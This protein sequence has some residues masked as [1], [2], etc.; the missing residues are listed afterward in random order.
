MD[1]FARLVRSLE[2][3]GVRFVLIGLAGAN[4]YARSGA[5]LFVTEDRDLLLPLDPDNALAAWGV[6][7]AM[8][9]QLR[10]GREPLDRPRDRF[11]A[12]RVVANRALVRATDGAGLDVD[13]SL[14][15]AGLDFETVWAERRVFRVGTVDIPVARLGQSSSRNVAWDARR[16]GCS[17]QRTPRRSGSSARPTSGSS[18]SAR[19][20]PAGESRGSVVGAVRSD[21][22]GSDF[23]A[24]APPPIVRT[25]GR[26]AHRAGGRAA[27]EPGIVNVA[28]N[29]SP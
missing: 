5:T 21:S 18:R 2:R 1:A 20:A 15:M 27:Y 16:T 24:E 22:A 8:G 3:A 4:Y 29:T 9:L 26:A 10:C 23:R 14:L 25:R 11:L 17:W 13:L 6:C 28:R 12:E 19:A 7:E